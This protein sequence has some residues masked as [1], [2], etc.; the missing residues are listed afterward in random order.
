MQLRLNF[1]PLCTIN[2]F[3]MSIVSDVTL[4]NGIVADVPE[5]NVQFQLDLECMLLQV[6]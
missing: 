3:K 2:T 1:M 6:F 5:E 4:W